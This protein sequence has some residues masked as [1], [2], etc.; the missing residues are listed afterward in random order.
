METPKIRS[1][2]E[3]K[4][5]LEAAQ[6]IVVDPEGKLYTPDA[7]EIKDKK[8]EG[9]TVVKPTRWFSEGQPSGASPQSG[10]IRDLKELKRRMEQAEEIMVDEQGRLIRPDSKDGKSKQE[11]GE[12]TFIKPTRW[13]A[14]S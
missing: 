1:L 5:R 12:G 4:R 9:K 7:P 11:K 6:E 2:D 10:T 13:F 3:L 8:T 14:I